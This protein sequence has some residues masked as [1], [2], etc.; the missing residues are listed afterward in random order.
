MGLKMKNCDSKPPA[1]TACRGGGLC[2]C[3]GA[4]TEVTFRNLAC[5]AC[6]AVTVTVKMLGI[7]RCTRAYYDTLRHGHQRRFEMPKPGR[8]SA[9][10]VH[11]PGA[12]EQG[13]SPGLQE[14]GYQRRLRSW[15]VLLRLCAGV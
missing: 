1:L 5:F 12:Q 4:Q 10:E 6:Y 15:V 11:P 3:R 7:S 2:I 9:R 13:H 14:R 8:G